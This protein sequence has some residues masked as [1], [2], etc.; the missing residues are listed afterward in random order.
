MFFSF[1]IVSLCIFSFKVV[2]IASAEVT[3]VN[4]FWKQLISSNLSTQLVTAEHMKMKFKLHKNVSPIKFS[5]K[6]TYQYVN[7][8]R[9][10]FV[11]SLFPAR[12]SHSVFWLTEMSMRQRE[13]RVSKKFAVF[14]SRS[15]FRQ[16]IRICIYIKEVYSIKQI[17]T[18]SALHT[19]QPASAGD[20]TYHVNVFIQQPIT[21]SE[22]L[23][24]WAYVTA[25]LRTGLFLDT[26]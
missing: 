25:F 3:T 6:K 10:N 24:H 4:K 1:V 17:I 20:P 5:K 14:V 22:Q 23:P 15:V 21:R 26:F 18:V 2:A 11:L 8:E 16:K 12:S 9:S 19:G 13:L 7:K